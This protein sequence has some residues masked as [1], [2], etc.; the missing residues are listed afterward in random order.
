[1]FRGQ[2][3]KATPIDIAREFIRNNVQI[4]ALRSSLPEKI[5]NKIRHS[6]L[7]LEKFTRVG[8]LLHYLQRFDINHSDP[9]YLQMKSHNLATFEDI[10]DDF[11]KQFEVWAHDSSRITDFVVGEEYSVYDV[12]ILARTYDTRAGG[13][14][15]LEADEKPTA[16]IIKATLSNGRYANEWIKEG[17]EL[18]YYLKSISGVFGEHFKP[19]RAILENKTI[20]IVTFTRDSDLVPFVFRGIF[21]YKGIIREAEERKAFVLERNGYEAK[22]I[23]D[24]A[25]AQRALD[26][27]VDMSIASSR[28]ERLR[29]L[30]VAK[31]QPPAY[32]VISTAFLRN[33]DV[34]AEVLYEAQGI[35]QLCKKPAPFSRRSDGT[36]YLEVHHRLP[37]A[38]GGADTV[39]NAIALCPNCHREQHFGIPY[40]ASAVQDL[41][42]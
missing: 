38:M 9:M 4:P 20:P 25:Y 2:T 19:N 16:V 3:D 27:M 36:P 30:A 42:K 14:F 17:E 41:P 31:K 40:A 5:K 26:K 32:S 10:V 22:L 24:S 37:L 34:I 7:W 12:L 35:C 29:R 1:V 8:D 18:K 11:A 13:M 23:T 15:V 28:A 39:Q 6:D 33:A 21:R